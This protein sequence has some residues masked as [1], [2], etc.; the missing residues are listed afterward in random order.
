MGGRTRSTES[1]NERERNT[2]LTLRAEASV[3]EKSTCARERVAGRHVYQLRRVCECG[4]QTC[5][6]ARTHDLPKCACAYAHS[7]S[8]RVILNDDDDTWAG[9]AERCIR[10]LLAC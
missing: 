9:G 1:I 10:I 5:T 8:Y 3:E 2:E 4:K 6:R 7:N